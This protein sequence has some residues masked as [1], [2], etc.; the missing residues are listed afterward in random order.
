M[1]SF[2][3]VLW[4][5]IFFELV[6][7]YFKNNK[8][9]F[10][11]VESWTSFCLEVRIFFIYHFPEKKGWGIHPEFNTYYK[12]FSMTTLLTHTVA[13]STKP[14]F[15]PKTNNQPLKKFLSLA[16]TWAKVV[17]NGKLL[18]FKVNFLC[19]KIPQSF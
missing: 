14:S 15:M 4:L 19:Q 8:K 18:T 5:F 11:A 3:E 7:L 9:S 6:T 13:H 1:R 2:C 10:I 17:K 12:V 16:L